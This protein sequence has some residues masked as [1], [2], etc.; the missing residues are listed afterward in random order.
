MSY[1]D[2][3][4]QINDGI[5]SLTNGLKMIWILSSYYSSEEKM[6]SL[7]ERISWQLCQN[8]RKNLSIDKLF[9]YINQYY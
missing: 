6:I 9:K 7:F 3:Y 2:R 5:P 8:I 1:T 4:K